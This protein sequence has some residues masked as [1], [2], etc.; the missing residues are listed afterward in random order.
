M[1]L[2]FFFNLIYLFTTIST[3]PSHSCPNTPEKED[4]LPSETLAHLLHNGCSLQTGPG[5]HQ[6][7]GW[8][9][10]V[11]IEEV[12][13]LIQLINITELCGPLWVK[14]K[15]VFCEDQVY[16]W[17]SKVAPLKFIS[18]PLKHHSQSLP[19][20]PEPS[21]AAVFCLY[22]SKPMLSTGLKPWALGVWKLPFL[23]CTLQFLPHSY[24]NICYELSCTTSSDRHYHNLFIIP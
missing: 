21:D 5:K 8:R 7:F 6:N 15:R 2:S 20:S 24:L 12:H 1:F 11:Y 17:I 13:L 9:K 23:A 22:C 16:S 19:S 18:K 3:F 14:G 4:T 10:G